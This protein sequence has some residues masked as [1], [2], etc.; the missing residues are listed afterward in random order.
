ME[1]FFIASHD[2]LIMYAVLLGFINAVL[3]S[4]VAIF[5][6]HVNYFPNAGSTALVVS[7]IRL[8]RLG[9]NNVINTFPRP[10]SYPPRLV[11]YLCP[12]PGAS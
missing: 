6:G 7:Q 12:L 5:S 3:A 1:Q 2:K 4:F 9:N 10:S 11:A 8:I